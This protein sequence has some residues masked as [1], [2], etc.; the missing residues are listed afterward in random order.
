MDVRKLLAIALFAGACGRF[1][2]ANEQ[3]PGGTTADAPNGDAS[4]GDDGSTMSST[5]YLACDAPAR[6]SVAATPAT[7]S[8]ITTTNG[9]DILEVDV[10]GN[11]TGWTYTFSSST[12]KLAALASGVALTT[13]ATGPIG[14]VGTGANIVCAEEYGRPN[15]TGTAT[16]ELD[17]HLKAV[18]TA[19]MRDN[20]FFDQGPMAQSGTSSSYAL[21]IADGGDDVTAHIVTAAG[22]DTGTTKDVIA[23]SEGASFAELKSGGAG[24]VA[25]WTTNASSPNA[26]RM[27]VLD[28]NL[29]IVAG[30]ITTSSPDDAQS[31]HAVWAKNAN[32][33]LLIWYEKN[34]TGGDDIY[35]E[36]RKADLSLVGAQVH[37][38]ASSYA[39]TVASDGDGFLVAWDNYVPSDHME[40]V[41]VDAQGASTGRTVVNSGGKPVQWT[42]TER[43]GQP[44]LVWLEDAGIGPNLYIDAV[45]N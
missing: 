16:G 38:R 45:C 29:K 25:T 13:N 28:D 26:V 4:P 3:P 18:G 41:Y 20:E 1:G 27:A 33:Y 37:A 19:T 43:L 9:Y 32:V 30:P 6:F 40:A 15:P 10:D 42:M 5:P 2:F 44:A 17:D 24:Y 12:G 34:A 7:L 11:V 23:A 22:A 31:P 36:V 14:G 35:Y 21:L 8:A 39:P